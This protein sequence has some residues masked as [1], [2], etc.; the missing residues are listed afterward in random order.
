MK[1]VKSLEWSRLLIKSVSETI[2]NEAKE[3]KGVF[4]EMLLGTLHAILLG[5]LLAAKETTR[6]GE[7]IFRTGKDTIRVGLGF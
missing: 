1:I 3:L 5:N 6:T 2:K 4:L 7:S